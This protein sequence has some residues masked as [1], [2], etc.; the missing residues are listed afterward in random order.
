MVGDDAVVSRI[1][2][3]EQVDGTGFCHAVGFFQGD[4]VDAVG[5]LEFEP[6]AVVDAGLVPDEHDF[7][8]LG[9]AVAKLVGTAALDDG[10]VVGFFLAVAGVGHVKATEVVVAQV[11]AEE[12]AG[13]DG[14]GV[15]FGVL[16][17]GIE[18]GGV[19]VVAVH[20]VKVP[21]AEFRALGVGIGNALADGLREEI[22]ERGDVL[23]SAGT[24]E[25]LEE[26]AGFDVGDIFIGVVLEELLAGGGGAQAAQHAEL[27]VVDVGNSR[28]VVWAGRAGIKGGDVGEE[29]LGELG[30]EQRVKGHGFFQKTNSLIGEHQMLVS[31]DFERAA[32]GFKHSRPR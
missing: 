7:A 15:A 1:V 29:S 19:V 30:V 26:V 6:M 14:A 17:F 24:F 12:M 25:R 20:G 22:V 13:G 8:A 2:A 28:A 16:G 27:A 21:A 4:E 3:V 10:D 9:R 32:H 31:C 23:K 5:V 11:E 18:A